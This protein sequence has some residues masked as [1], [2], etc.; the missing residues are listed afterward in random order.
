MSG[1]L[2]LVALCDGITEYITAETSLG[3]VM[4]LKARGAKF[5][6]IPKPPSLT[7]L[8]PLSFQ[9]FPFQENRLRFESERSVEARI[10]YT[11]LITPPR[12]MVYAELC[13]DG[14]DWA[15]V[16]RDLRPVR[17][18]AAVDALV[19]VVLAAVAA[20]AN[21]RELIER[22]VMATAVAVVAGF[23]THVELG[24]ATCVAEELPPDPMP[25]EID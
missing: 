17:C 11:Q 13:D 18:R 10:G 1:H 5:Y 14:I 7:M 19:G 23:G 20:W 25:I 21:H 3:R 9:P 15:A 12:P 4:Q 22:L 2:D 24:G 16:E 6:K 8:A